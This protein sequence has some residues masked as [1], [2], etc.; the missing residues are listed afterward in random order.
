MDTVTQDYP[1]LPNSENTL[2]DKQ[3]SA[4][5]LLIAGKGYGETARALEIER[6]T[7]YNWRQDDLF[8]E[9]LQDRRRELW[10]RANDRIRSLLETSIDVMEQHLKDNWQNNR[11]RAASTLLRVANLRKSIAVE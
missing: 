8:Q 5:E 9:A 6:K 3:L 1:G 2:S 11:F 10:G 7:L 4:I